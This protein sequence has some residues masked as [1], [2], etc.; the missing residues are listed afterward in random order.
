M[1]GV[2]VVALPPGVEIEDIA[3]S[4]RHSERRQAERGHADEASGRPGVRPVG[5]GCTGH[6]Q[7]A[8]ATPRSA[9]ARSLETVDLAV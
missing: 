4:Q 1:E 5:R 7:P 3:A 8:P 2:E 6:G 9:D